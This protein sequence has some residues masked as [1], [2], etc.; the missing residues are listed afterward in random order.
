MNREELLMKAAESYWK[1][2][3]IEKSIKWNNDAD[4]D[5]KLAKRDQ[6]L[7]DLLWYSVASQYQNKGV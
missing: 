5:S 6:A 2:D 7:F 3:R 1:A 4:R